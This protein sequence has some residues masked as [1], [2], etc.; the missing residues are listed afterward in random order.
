LLTR[1]PHGSHPPRP[2]VALLAGGVGAARFLR[3]LVRHVPQSRLT[4][5]VNTGDDEEFYGLHVSPD[6]DTITYTLAGVVDPRQGW[7]LAGDSFAALG[8]LARFY[9]APW[10]RLGDRDLATHIFRT[11]RLKQGAPLSAVTAEIARRFGVRAR[12]LPMSDD[13]VRTFVRLKRGGLVPFQDYF[14]R[15]RFRARVQAIEL[16]GLFRARPLPALLEAIARCAAVILAPS[17]PF[18]SLGPILR[19]SGVAAALRKVRPR[20]AAISPLIRG[21]AVKGPAHRMMRTLGHQPSAL[22]VARLY[23]D[24]AGIFV[25]DRSDRRYAEAIERLG[26][27]PI[28]T[29]I[30]MNSEQAAARLA[31]VVLDAVGL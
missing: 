11:A 22:G 4:V 29:D 3:G 23:R 1:R 19:L 27:R 15:R 13:R 21:R 5:A 30:L 18:V 6:L 14:V 20:V 12:V 9:G 24:V 25:L 7:G 26:M 16:R 31:K 2:A 17:N 28:V 8:A 10:F